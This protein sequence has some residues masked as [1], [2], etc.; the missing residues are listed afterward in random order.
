MGG[1]IDNPS[2]PR[3]IEYALHTVEW[4]NGCYAKCESMVGSKVGVM[5]KLAST[6]RGSEKKIKEKVIC[7]YVNTNNSVTIE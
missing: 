6:C 1:R 4:D 3:E 7:L 2:L 5:E